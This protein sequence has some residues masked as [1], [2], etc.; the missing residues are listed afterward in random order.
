MGQVRQVGHDDQS[1]EPSDSNLA[2]ADPQIGA[3]TELA[4]L[5]VGQESAPEES[6]T[7]SGRTRAGALGALGAQ[8][9]AGLVADEFIDEVLE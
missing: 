9:E 7:V 6:S 5:K 4:D 1:T 3:Q 2:G 8:M